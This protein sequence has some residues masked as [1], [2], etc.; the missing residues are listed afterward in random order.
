MLRQLPKRKRKLESKILLQNSVLK[1]KTTRKLC[2]FSVKKV[3]MLNISKHNPLTLGLSK[4]KSKQRLVLPEQNH[5][6]RWVLTAP[7][8]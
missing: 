6:G 7:A 1:Q 4:L 2:V 3:S 5:L 8:M